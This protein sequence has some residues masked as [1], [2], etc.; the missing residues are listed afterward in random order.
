M[1]PSSPIKAPVSSKDAVVEKQSCSSPRKNAPVPSDV[2]ES[3]E[4][5]ASLS[6]EIPQ[7]DF[8]GIEQMDCLKD[9]TNN[10]DSEA[11]QSATNDTSEAEN[12]NVNIKIENEI[13]LE[14]SQAIDDENEGDSEVNDLSL[15]GESDGSKN[16]QYCIKIFLQL[17]FWYLFIILAFCAH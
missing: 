5:L 14:A 9:K 1:V 13:L 7:K 10:Q 3:A 6:N 11:A 4:I 16:G 15:E 8:A 12:Q 17:F 2:A